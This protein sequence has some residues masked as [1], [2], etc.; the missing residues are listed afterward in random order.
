MRIIDWIKDN[1]LILIIGFLVFLGLC[2]AVFDIILLVK[3]GNKSIEETPT[4]VL[5]FLWSNRR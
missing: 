3:Y 5:W 4:W 2:F 1:F